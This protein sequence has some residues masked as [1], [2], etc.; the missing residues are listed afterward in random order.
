M[1]KSRPVRIK[2]KVVGR[3]EGRTYI[4]YRKP[5]HIYQRVPCYQHNSFCPGF[6]FSTL[7]LERLQEWGVEVIV[8]RVREHAAE[9][10][11][12]LRHV[13]SYGAPITDSRTLES[14]RALPLHFFAKFPYRPRGR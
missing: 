13:L 5:E 10:V 8:V 12:Y 3:V 4:T 2:G 1:V 6:A 14:Q 7:L 11:G 9:Y